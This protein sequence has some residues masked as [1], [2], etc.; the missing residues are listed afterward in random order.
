MTEGTPRK[1]PRK[2][3]RKS[4]TRKSTSPKPEDV[5][6]ESEGAGPEPAG[7]VH[8][9]S[10]EKA[11]IK[12]A[13]PEGE[14]KPDAETKSESLTGEAPDVGSGATAAEEDEAQL[15]TAEPSAEVLQ[16][17]KGMFGSKGSGDTAI[18]W[19]VGSGL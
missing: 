13:V 9:E 15:T 4:T 12:G 14:S 1:P 16:A 3:T 6:P 5:Q 2:R 8:K 10:D 18:R 19:L 7:S 17:R 11:P